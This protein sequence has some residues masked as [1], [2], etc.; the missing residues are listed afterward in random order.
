MAKIVEH[1][2]YWKEAVQKAYKDVNVKCPEC[3]SIILTNDYYIYE[4]NTTEIWCTCGCKFIPEESDI[5]RKEL[6]K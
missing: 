3:D 6:E 5:L 2:K 4:D 1:G